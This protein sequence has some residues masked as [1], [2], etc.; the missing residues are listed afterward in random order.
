MSVINLATPLHD[1][2]G[3]LLYD[4][5]FDKSLAPLILVSAA[6]TALI[7]PLVPLLGRAARS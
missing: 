1:T 3:A 4:H 5:V 7:L 6:A 2:I